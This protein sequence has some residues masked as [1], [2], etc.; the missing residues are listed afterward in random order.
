V[1]FHFVTDIANNGPAFFQRDGAGNA[2]LKFEEAEFFT[3]GTA[4]SVSAS[5]APSDSELVVAQEVNA[6]PSEDADYYHDGA[7]YC[8][9]EERIEQ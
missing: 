7:P 6:H 2:A 9:R 5:E 4:E 3:Y 1:E 8:L